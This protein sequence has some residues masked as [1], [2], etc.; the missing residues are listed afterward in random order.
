[1][2]LSQFA[3]LSFHAKGTGTL[4]PYV[5]T[6]ATDILDQQPLEASISL[7]SQWTRY[8]ITPAELKPHAGTVAAQ[9]GLGWTDVG[10]AAR[11]IGFA[12]RATGEVCLDSLAIE[13]LGVLRYR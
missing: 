7:S 13:G 4:Y 5:Q 8:R 12:M 9:Q 1:M 11:A 3:A 2:D 6:Q 10:N